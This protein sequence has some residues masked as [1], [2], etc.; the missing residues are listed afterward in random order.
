[1]EAPV[2]DCAQFCAHPT[3][4]WPTKPHLLIDER[5]PVQRVIC[6]ALAAR[7]VFVVGDAPDIAVVRA[8]SAVAQME[9]VA[10]VIHVAMMRGIGVSA[11]ERQRACA[12]GHAAGLQAFVVAEEV[13]DG[14]CATAAAYKGRQRAV[15]CAAV[16]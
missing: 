16:S 13:G 1:V 15:V 3:E 2:S 7:A 6:E 11:V 9:V 12:G 8:R 5:E 10:D 14:R 4:T